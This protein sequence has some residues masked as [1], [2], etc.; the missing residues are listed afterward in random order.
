M[1]GTAVADVMWCYVQGTAVADV[2]WCYVQCIAVAGVVMICAG[3]VETD[4]MKVTYL[5][6]V[7]VSVV[8]ITVN[9]FV[10][11]PGV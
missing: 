2:M 11:C 5:A 7:C 10:C 9:F 6:T 1:Q 4:D 3:F 8:S